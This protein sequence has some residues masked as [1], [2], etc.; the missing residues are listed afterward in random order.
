MASRLL[1][2]FHLLALFSFLPFSFSRLIES[3]LKGS[4]AERLVLLRARTQP[5]RFNPSKSKQIS[6]HPRVSLYEG[7]LSDDECDHLISLAH[8]KIEKHVVIDNNSTGTQRAIPTGKKFLV[9][10]EQ[11]EIL[12]KIEERIS[13]WTMLPKEHGGGIQIWNYRVN[14]SYGPHYDFFENSEAKPGG[15]RVATVLMYLSN[16]THGSETVFLKSQTKYYKLKDENL[17]ECALAGY[18][19]KPVKGNAV[20]FFNLNLDL[21]PDNSSQHEV[22]KVL[23]GEK[24]SATM[25]FHMGPVHQR[26]LTPALT[27]PVDQDECTDEDDN[28]ASWA[29]L[30]EC[31]RNPVFMLGSSD[32]SGACRK[33]CKAC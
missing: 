8:G 22:C 21:T 18:A 5:V 32:Y 23:E 29:E 30:G 16:V 7:F 20:F 3:R 15:N 14:D 11:D 31:E 17:S 2:F 12:S 25:Y 9:N 33:S 4:N 10:S 13:L 26:E 6:W 28:C 19:I 27:L 24:W 1:R